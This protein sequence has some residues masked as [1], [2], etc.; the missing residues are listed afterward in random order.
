MEHVD[1]GSE[2]SH[3]MVCILLAVLEKGRAERLQVPETAS[4]RGRGLLK[5]ASSTLLAD[6][7]LVGPATYSW[8]CGL[9][10]KAHRETLQEGGHWRT[11]AFISFRG[12]SKNI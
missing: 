9:T 3:G 2:T 1:A 5:T 10:C 6:H 7:V 12:S 8:V 4:W 11:S